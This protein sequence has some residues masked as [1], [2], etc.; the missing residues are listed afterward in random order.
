MPEPANSPSRWP[1]RQAAK[2]SAPERRGRAAARAGRARRRAGRAYRTERARTR[3]QRSPPIE[4]AAQRI[5]DAA[6]PILRYGERCA[7]AR[8]EEAHGRPCRASRAKPIQRAECHRLRDT[9]TEADDFGR[10]RCAVARDEVETI[11]DG[12]VASEPGDAHQKARKRADPTLQPGVRNT[13]DRAGCDAGP[14]NETCLP[15]LVYLSSII[16]RKV[17]VRGLIRPVNQP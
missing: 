11:A 9:V 6:Q 7:R 2:V 15:H 1:A 13:P 16:G 4:R 12:Q 10:D 8:T 17:T 3:G 14:L 5:E